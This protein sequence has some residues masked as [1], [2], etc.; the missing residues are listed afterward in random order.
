MINF[1][2]FEFHLNFKRRQEIS[3]I[4]IIAQISNSKELSLYNGLQNV[5]I[6]RVN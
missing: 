5:K 4:I 2:L 6:P 1:M 3:T